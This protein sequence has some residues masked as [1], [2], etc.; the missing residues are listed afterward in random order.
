[1]IVCSSQVLHF[2][3]GSADERTCRS[4]V[5]TEIVAGSPYREPPHNIE[6]EQAPLGAMLINND[7]FHRV[8]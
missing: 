6:A 4:S 3:I 5:Q 2:N 1:M 8:A 7:A